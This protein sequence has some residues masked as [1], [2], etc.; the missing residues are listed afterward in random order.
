MT[1]PRN[2][3]TQRRLKRE[4]TKI[5]SEIARLR[6]LRP[7]TLSEQYDICGTPDVG[8]RLFDCKNMDRI[9]N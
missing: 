6:D 4:I 1:N 2:S 9:T 8:V 7:E 3:K 5:K